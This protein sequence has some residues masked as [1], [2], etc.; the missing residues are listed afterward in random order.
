MAIARGGEERRCWERAA[1][2]TSVRG[3]VSGWVL[4]AGVIDATQGATEG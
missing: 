2:R 1:V 3:P 4:L